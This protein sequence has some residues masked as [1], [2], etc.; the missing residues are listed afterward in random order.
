VANLDAMS[1]S[2]SRS[3]VAVGWNPGRNDNEAQGVVIRTLDGG[4]TW[5]VVRTLP[6]GVG[7]LRGVSCPTATICMAVGQSSD[8]TSGSALLTS[9][10][11]GRWRSLSLPKGQEELA[12]VT[13][14]TRRTCIGEGMMD[15]TMGMPIYGERPGVISTKDGGATWTLRALPVG[16]IGQ[17]GVPSFKGMA[18][19]SPNRCYMVGDETPGDGSPSGV[20]S[21][22]TDGGKTWTR[23]TLPAGTTSLNAISCA[24]PTDCVVVGGGIGPRG[25]TLHD[26]LATSDGGQ[27][28]VSRPVPV[29]T[30]SVL[31]LSSVSCP[32]ITVCMATGFG[33]T[34]TTPS[35]EPSVVA[36]T[37]DGGATWTAMR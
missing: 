33:L 25:E 6:E 3:C 14:T 36:V 20:I 27:T 34:N 15:V 32:S 18:C 24:A 16:N 9:S 28:W 8:G 37:S 30:T 19:P 22:S 4:H 7:V 13:C 23:P 29:A 17:Q 12:L 31:G 1:C 35:M 26:I 2:T 11:G 21:V 5:N 10:S